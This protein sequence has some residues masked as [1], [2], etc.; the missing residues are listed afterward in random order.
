[1]FS[2]S[3]F[4]SVRKLLAIFLFQANME[5]SAEIRESIAQLFCITIPKDDDVLKRMGTNIKKT[6]DLR[7][8]HFLYFVNIYWKWIIRVQAIQIIWSEVYILYF[9]IFILW[10]S[11]Q[12][13]ISQNFH[14][15]E[16]SLFKST[17]PKIIKEMLW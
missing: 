3:C 10:T 13:K 6:V 7:L 14:K 5:V 15:W 4:S 8:H 12:W 11:F 9:L 17:L 16:S 2:S 1:M